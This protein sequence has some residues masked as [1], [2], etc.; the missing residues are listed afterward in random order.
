VVKSAKRVVV[1]VRTTRP[2]EIGDKM[3][4]RFGNKGIVTTILA[5]KEMP[6]DAAGEPVHVL[7]SP[8]G[9][10]SRMNLG[11]VLETVAGKIAKKTGKPYVVDNFQT[12]VD[13]SAKV[14]SEL[15]RHGLSDTDELFDAQSGASLGPVLTGF[16]YILKLDHQ[17]EKKQT[18]R[19][20]G[21][22]NKY[23]VHGT[24]PS[25]AGIPGGGQ[26]LGLLD[27]YAM[28]AHGAH[29]QPARDGRPGRATSTRATSGSR[30]RK[31]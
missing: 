12:G 3:A 11:Q 16:Q 31:A 2:M 24:A 8:A 4:G 21:A 27:T 7:L 28:L 5:D 29:A 14:Q 13:Y 20:A 17:A 1:Y 15:D 25:G 19:S 6:R 26:K 9:V 18:A 10:P 30:S 22:G 23:G